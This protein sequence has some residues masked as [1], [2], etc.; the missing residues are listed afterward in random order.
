MPK[1]YIKTYGCQMNERDSEQVAQMFVEGGYTLTRRRER[2][3]MSILIN[4]CSR[5]RPGRAEGARQDGH[6]GQVPRRR[7]RT[8]S[9]ASWAAWR[10]AAAR[11]S[12]SASRT[13]TSSSA[14]R[15]TTG[16]STTWTASCRR[17]RGEADGRPALRSMAC[18]HATRRR[19]ESQNTIRDH[20]AERTPGHRL[21]LDHAGLQ[22]A[23]HLLHRARHPRRRSAAARSPRS[24]R[25]CSGSSTRGVEGGHPA[26]P[27]REP[28]RPPR[29]P[30]G[31][32]QESL[33]AVARS[34]ARDR[35]PRAHPLH[36]AA[37][38]RLPR[39]PGRRL[40]LPAEALPHIHFPMQSGSRPHPEGDAPAVQERRSSSRSARR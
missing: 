28:L 40:H 16:S 7:S 33:R 17:R 23:L 36:L 27:D 11:N 34:G 38:D 31:G 24:S 14:R 18:D 32:W 39:R 9:S 10:R 12:S 21:R 5:A 26:R 35:R 2:T 19:K 25:K 22:H 29:V 8:S 3:P 4:T 20:V 6:D 30:E 13:S 1:V 37:P 15:N